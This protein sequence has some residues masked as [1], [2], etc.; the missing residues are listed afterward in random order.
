MKKIILVAIVLFSFSESFSQSYVDNALLLSRFQPSGSARIQAVGGSQVALGGDYS[1]AFSNPAGLGMYNRNEFT[2]SAGYGQITSESKYLGMTGKESKSTLHVPGLSLVLHTPSDRETGFLGGSFAITLSR[3]NDLHQN[4]RYQGVNSDHSIIDY[5]VQDAEGIDPDE[6]LAN[7]NNN[8]GGFYNSLTGLAYRNYLIEEAYDQQGVFYGSVAHYFDGDGVEYEVDQRRQQEI[9]ERKGAQY[10]WSIAYGANFSDKFF[11]GANL[12][13]STL[14]YKLSLAYTEDNFQENGSDFEPF[15]EIRMDE[16]FDLRGSGINLSAG[17]I[18]RPVEF[19][20]FGASFTSPTYYQITDTYEASMGT[21]WNN[22]DYFPDI[23]N[24]EPLTTI[25][26][27]FDQP[28]LYEYNLNTPMRLRGG[29]TFLSKIGFITTDVEFVNY[30]KAKY[31]SDIAGEFDF[32]NESIRTEFQSVINYSAGGEFRAQ[33]WRLRAGYNMQ[34]E[35]FRNENTGVKRSVATYS[36]GVGYRASNFFIDLTG[37]YSQTEG[38]R[39][40]YL[41]DNATDPLA[42][43]TFTTFRVL[44]TI[45]FTF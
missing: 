22:Y 6:F 5:F 20:Q 31:K 32:D 27:S 8:L 42:R 2:F 39:S 19:L 35:P 36:A 11:I 29:A 25:N 34:S 3:T 1:S 15:R 17:A 24:D 18:Y 40:P 9:F 44:A 41:L 14:R 16:T 12:G 38:S 45:G 4:Y 26:E 43:L 13:I 21:I 30:G 10:Q 23:S 37:L 33:N 7:G 28:S